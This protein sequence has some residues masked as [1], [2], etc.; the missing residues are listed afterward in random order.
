MD[1]AR[2][3]VNRCW[4]APTAPAAPDAW[5]TSTVTI[6]TATMPRAIFCTPPIC[7]PY[8]LVAD[9]MFATKDSPLA[10][11]RIS[12]VTSAI[13]AIPTARVESICSAPFSITAAMHVATAAGIAYSSPLGGLFIPALT[14]EMSPAATSGPVDAP[15]HDTPLSTSCSPDGT[16]T[17][18]SGHRSEAR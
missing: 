11:G 14:M 9:V 2:E 8:S 5:L 6:P 17:P 16:P 7:A 1:V 15:I 4:K 10:G 18:R 12:D 13:H 3:L